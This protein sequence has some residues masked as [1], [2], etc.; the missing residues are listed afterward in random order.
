MTKNQEF[1]SK[2][3][4]NEFMKERFLRAVFVRSA[5]DY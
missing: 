5:F 4:L 1:I 3:K 2:L